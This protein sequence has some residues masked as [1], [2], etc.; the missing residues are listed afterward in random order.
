MSIEEQDPYQE[1]RQQVDELHSKLEYDRGRR[2]GTRNVLQ[3]VA[4]VVTILVSVGLLTL[5]RNTQQFQQETIRAIESAAV[6]RQ[7]EVE[8]TS[9]ARQAT[10]EFEALEARLHLEGTMESG[11]ANVFDNFEATVTSGEG[12]RSADAATRSSRRIS[13]LGTRTA[14]G[15]AA[16][17]SE[18]QARNLEINAT[19]E[20]LSA[21]VG[22][23]VYESVDAS[24]D[25]EALQ[26]AAITIMQTRIDAAV[27]AS[28]AE[29]VEQSVQATTQ[30]LELTATAEA[31]LTPSPTAPA[32]ESIV[33]TVTPT[34]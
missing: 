10:V 22:T 20:M 4:V 34:P 29:A 32:Q 30:A 15:A 27:T 14:E 33:P 5:W 16:L 13:D 6:T 1:V 18:L 2:E 7:V 11:I 26:S 19:A 8:S 28:F 12:T 17:Q 31:P 21:A 9:V 3:I 24:I 25:A 23:Q